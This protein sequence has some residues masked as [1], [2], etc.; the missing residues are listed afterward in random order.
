MVD[1]FN[2]C[3]LV[4]IRALELD[5]NLFRVGQSKVFFRAGVLAHLEEE[6]DLKITDTI[7]RFQSVSRG[8]LARK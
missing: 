3:S 6:R 8:Y 1:I 4:Q 2:R 5:H 7:I